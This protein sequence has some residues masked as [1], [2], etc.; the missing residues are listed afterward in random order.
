[1]LFGRH[2][3]EARVTRSARVPA[4][5]ARARIFE[6]T[7]SLLRDRRFRDISVA[8]VMRESGLTRTVFYRYF[9]GMPDVLLGLLDD[10]LSAV[11]E[12]DVVGDPRD[13]DLLRRELAA[14]VEIYRRHGRLLLALEEAAHHDDQLEAAYRAWYERTVE[15]TAGLIQ[16]GIDL[17]HTPPLNVEETARALTVMNGHYLLELIRKDPA[18][19]VDLALETLLTIWTRCTW[20]RVAGAGV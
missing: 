9:A 6:A 10:L 18:F 1:M 11:L 16:R 8:E 20:P 13:R 14:A 3:N 5:Q 17:G 15:V 4:P 12:E 2:G 19:D 7:A